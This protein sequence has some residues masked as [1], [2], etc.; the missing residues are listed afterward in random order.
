MAKF[1]IAETTQMRLY[2]AHRNGWR[3]QQ[4]NQVK[5]Y[6]YKNDSEMHKAYEQGRADYRKH[7]L[8]RLIS[9]TG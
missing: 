2:M 7:K 3:D 8:T 4:H 1:S 9:G 5:K 6:L